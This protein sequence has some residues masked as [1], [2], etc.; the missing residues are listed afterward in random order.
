MTEEQKEQM[1]IAINRKIEQHWDKLVKDSKQVSGYNY[2]NYGPDLLMFC[3]SE[4]LTKKDLEYQYKVAVTDNKL[5]NYIGR[6]MSLNIR[7]SNSPFYLKYRRDLMNNRGIYEAEYENSAYRTVDYQPDVIDENFDLDKKHKS[8]V[9]CMEYAVGQLDFYYG[10]LV[11]KY[12]Y[13][14]YTIKQIAEYYEIPKDSIQNDLKK[15]R[16]MLRQHCNHFDI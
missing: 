12:Y 6:A 10:A 9:D 5:P 2:N 1:R 3:I 7:S 11:N 13:Q 15:A 4:F 8:P 16:K 14:K